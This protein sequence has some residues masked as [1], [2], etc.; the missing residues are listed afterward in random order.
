MWRVWRY[1]V[2]VIW[3]GGSVTLNNYGDIDAD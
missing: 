3:F 1:E 2:V